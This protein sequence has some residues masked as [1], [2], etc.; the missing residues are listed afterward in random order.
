MGWAALAGAAG[1]MGLNCALE[2]DPHVPQVPHVPHVPHVPA[3]ERAG[4]GVLRV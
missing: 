1:L 2:R 3:S 4:L